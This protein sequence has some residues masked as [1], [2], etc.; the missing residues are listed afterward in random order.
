MS[1]TKLAGVALIIIGFLGVIV[2][3]VAWA[4]CAIADAARE[5]DRATRELVGGQ[6]GERS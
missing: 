3:C 1:L 4:A 2:A 5:A 6:R